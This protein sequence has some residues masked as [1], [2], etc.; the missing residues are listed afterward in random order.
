MGCLETVRGNLAVR[1][2]RRRIEPVA[3]SARLKAKTL[4][5]YILRVDFFL[6]KKK[7]GVL[8]MQF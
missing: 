2:F 7:I 6:V 4:S 1:P 3:F 5:A 8:R